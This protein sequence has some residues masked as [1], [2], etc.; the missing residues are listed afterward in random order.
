MK[1]AGMIPIERENLTSA[2]ATIRD[3]GNQVIK[4]KK[5]MCIAAEGTRRRSDSIGPEHLLPLKK[6]PFHMAK[7]CKVDI[8]PAAIIGANRLFAPGQMFPR[9]GTKTF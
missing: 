1:I 4:E 7:S 2:I 9:P 5:T 6:G 3:A 8:V